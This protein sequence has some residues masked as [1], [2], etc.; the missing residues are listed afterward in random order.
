MKKTFY[1]WYIVAGGFVLCFMGIGVI[2]NTSS[3]FFKPVIDTYGFSRGDLSLYFTIAAVSMMVMAPFVGT[4]LE[5]FDVRLVMGLSS[6][7]MALAFMAYSRC[8]TLAQFYIVSVF[9][10]LGSAGA[11]FIPVSMMLNNWFEEKRGLVMGIVYSS[12]A[13]GGFIFSPLVNWL[14]ARFGWQESYL[15]LGILVAVTAVPISI[16][17][18]RARPGDVGLRP[19]GSSIEDSSAPRGESGL[20]LGE[21]V[22]TTSFWLL[23]GMLFLLSVVSLGVQQHIIPY[24][25][26]IGHTPGFGAA[27]LALFMGMLVI[28]KI[29]LGVLSDALGLKKAVVVI[30]IVYALT[31]ATLFGARSAT[32][33]VVFALLFGF[34]N[35]AHTVLPPLLTAAC[36]GPKHFALLF[37]IMN[38]FITLGSGVGMPLSGYIYDWSGSYFPAF[39][40]YIACMLFCIALGTF[41]LSRTPLKRS[42]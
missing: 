1:G 36:L 28:G 27:M 5:R 29:A 30:F 32:V 10:G 40:I 14:I 33:A 31:V 38:I 19:Y 9:L 13:A 20:S 17:V 25:T 39:G 24:L 6:A 8:T 22:R 34:S 16:F 35:A 23:G 12:S 4:L 15:F 41:A 3:V 11:H 42:R 26:D 18:M 2:I 37:G 21:S 7:V